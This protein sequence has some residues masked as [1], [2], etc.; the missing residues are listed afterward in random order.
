MSRECGRVDA[1][2]VECAKSDSRTVVGRGRRC[3]RRSPRTDAST[4]RASLSTAPQVVVVVVVVA[5]LL[6]SILTCAAALDAGTVVRGVGREGFLGALGGPMAAAAA[7]AAVGR[8]GL[9]ARCVNRMGSVTTE[10]ASPRSPCTP[11]SLSPPSPSLA[12]SATMDIDISVTVPPASSSERCTSHA[13]VEGSQLSASESQAGSITTS[14]DPDEG[15]VFSSAHSQTS[16][17]EDIFARRRRRQQQQQQQQQQQLKEEED[18]EDEDEE[19]AEQ[20]AHQQELKQ[21]PFQDTSTEPTT[22][23]T[24]RTD[25]AT[26]SQ[27]DLEQHLKQL[28]HA[29]VRSQWVLFETQTNLHVQLRNCA[30]QLTSSADSRPKLPSQ[31][32]EETSAHTEKVGVLR[33]Q[34]EQ[35]GMMLRNVR[36]HREATLRQEIS[37]RQAQLDELASRLA[38][39]E[40]TQQHAHKELK[41]LE[42]MRLACEKGEPELVQLRRRL[43]LAEEE[44]A[45]LSAQSDQMLCSHGEIVKMRLEQATQSAT[46]RSQRETAAL[47]LLLG[48][49]EEAQEALSK[50]DVTSAAN[51]EAMQGRIDPESG[52][53]QLLAEA[54]LRQWSDAAFPVVSKRTDLI[55]KE[56]EIYWGITLEEDVAT[57]T[58]RL[59]TAPTVAAA[60]ATAA[61]KVSTPP[62]TRSTTQ[63]DAEVKPEGLTMFTPGNATSTYPQEAPSTQSSSFESSGRQSAH[64]VARTLPSMLRSSLTVTPVRYKVTTPS[65][66]TSKSPQEP[67]STGKRRRNAPY[68]ADD[69]LALLQYVSEHGTAGAQGDAYWSR[70]V[71]SNLLQSKDPAKPS[72]TANS[73]R[74]R[75]RKILRPQYEAADGNVAVAVATKH[76]TPTVAAGA[77]STNTTTRRSSLEGRTPQ[78]QG[79]STRRQQVPKAVAN[80]LWRRDCGESFNGSCTVCEQ[81]LTVHNF[82]AGHVVSDNHGG[83]PELHN[84]RVICGPCN[85]S[86]GTKNLFDFKAEFFGREQR[87]QQPTRAVASSIIDLRSDSSCSDDNSSHTL[88]EPEPEPKSA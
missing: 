46:E 5:A 30:T 16:S 59:A 80:A 10:A 9:V 51:A 26:P 63:P 55:R 71:S 67:P 22:R 56:A 34:I 1:C 36:E 88:A 77:G 32:I 50:L 48:R 14:S 4:Q 53:L 57:R 15:A 11:S 74:E 37:A 64:A 83:A 18:D 41:Q 3:P 8:S 44:V 29:F 76:A 7:A 49:P 72:R 21:M 38:Q 85:K 45:A 84:L 33:G 78:R 58:P 52:A 17:D 31:L 23:V 73:L 39:G 40:H 13:T 24:A 75:W 69:D 35:S 42:R 61:M 66:S 20:E 60:A 68:T 70:A 6:G 47:N 27:Q 54:Q 79:G 82:E 19:E 28:L 12:L 43:R 25:T 81:P 62:S 2:R 86:C 65:D 87:R